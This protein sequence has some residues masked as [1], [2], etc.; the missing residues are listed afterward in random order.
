MNKQEIFDTVF[1]ALKKQKQKC[2]DGDGCV[3]ASPNHKRRCAVGQ[4]MD[5]KTALRL[6][7]E[8]YTAERSYYDV[9]DL[10]NRASARKL[11]NLD[12]AI[13]NK[14]NNLLLARL[15]QAHDS[16]LTCDSD[17]MLNGNWLAEMEAIAHKFKLNAKVM[18]LKKVKVDTN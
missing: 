18:K 14:K 17:G 8:R 16:S 10:C 3:Y 2:T 15:Q 1:L 12:S 7:R 9:S 11:Y 4:L 13:F 6:E 5:R